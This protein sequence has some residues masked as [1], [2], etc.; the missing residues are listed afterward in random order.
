MVEQTLGRI[1]HDPAV[2]DAV[3]KHHRHKATV[4]EF[5][6]VVGR[7]GDHGG[8]GAVGRPV[9]ADDLEAHEVVHVETVGGLGQRLGQQRQA[10]EAL[11]GRAIGEFLEVDEPAG[12]GTTGRGDREPGLAG[13]QTRTDREAFLA[14]SD[15][16]DVDV[17]AHAV[18]AAGASDLAERHV[19]R[20]NRR[21]HRRRRG[22]PLPGRRSGCSVRSGHDGR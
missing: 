7:V 8:T 17:A 9:A 18:R 11:C 12:A 4:L 10:H 16:V 22:W 1:D 19:S 14:V 3:D 15:Q 13:L 21:R 2:D 5:E 6:E 20:R